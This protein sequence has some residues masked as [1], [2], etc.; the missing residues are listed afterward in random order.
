M[1]IDRREKHTRMARLLTDFEKFPGDIVGD[2]FYAFP[3][4]SYKDSKGRDRTWRIFIRL[5]KDGHRQTEYDWDTLTENTINLKKDMIVV[6]TYKFPKE[7]LVQVWTEVGIVDGKVTRHPPTYIDEGKNMGRAN[8][9]N[10]FQTAM[11]MAR[12]KYLLKTRHSTNDIHTENTEIHSHMWFPM[13][14]KPLKDVPEIQFP[15][16]VQM[17]YDGL[18]CLAFLRNDEVILYTRQKKQYMQLEY[19][20]KELRPILK[21]AMLKGESLYLDGELYQHG[22]HLQDISGTARRVNEAK[23]V[24]LDYVVYDCFYPSTEEGFEQRQIIL[25]D[26]LSGISTKSHVKLAPKYFVKS[27]KQLDVVYK[28]FIRDGYEGAIVRTING[29]YLRKV[30]QTGAFLR[31]RDVIKIKKKHTDEFKIVGFT[32]GQGKDT[33]AV[34]WVL[35]TPEG[36]KFNVTPKQ[37]YPERKEI[38]ARL[39]KPGIFDKEYSGLMMTVEYED[40]SNDSIPL[41]AKSVGVRNE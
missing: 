35:E 20:E 31:S 2:T 12:D 32:S 39:K 40:L 14:A 13:L 15:V 6:A 41:R 23:D 33:D 27:Q 19:L 11:I 37:T 29:K 36:K 16:Y 24:Q 34:I 10:M 22:M 4:V 3:T 30:D 7:C 25:E 1:K 26:A 28:T 17:K 9:R 38:F 18:R 5:V 21:K 8:Q